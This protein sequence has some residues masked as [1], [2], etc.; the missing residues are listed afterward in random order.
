MRGYKDVVQR[1]R[2]AAVAVVGGA[3]D[4]DELSFAEEL[5]AVFDDLV[6]ESYLVGSAD[7]V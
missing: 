2:T 4:G 7:K 1:R 3:E 6:K 5:V